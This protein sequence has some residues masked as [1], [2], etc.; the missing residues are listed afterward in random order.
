MAM[1]AE[2]RP[3]CGSD[4]SEAIWCRE[5]TYLKEWQTCLNMAA[6]KMKYEK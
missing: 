1:E 2:I 5:C 3:L 6:S 4:K